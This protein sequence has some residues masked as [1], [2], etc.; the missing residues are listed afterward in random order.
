MNGRMISRVIEMQDRIIGILM[1]VSDH[2]ELQNKQCPLK[3]QSVIKYI[4]FKLSEYLLTI[5]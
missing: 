3:E 1:S 2:F 4:L 5:Q